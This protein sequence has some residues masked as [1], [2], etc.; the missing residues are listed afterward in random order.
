MA[1]IAYFIIDGLQKN[2]YYINNPIWVDITSLEGIEYVRLTMIYEGDAT[3]QKLY[4]NNSKTYFDIAPIV[5]GFMPAPKHPDTFVNNQDLGTNWLTLGITM[6]TI[7][8]SGTVIGVKSFFKTFVRGG[9]A[10]SQTN[11]F[12]NP[13]TVL[14]ESHLIPRWDAY[15]VV[16]YFINTYGFVSATNI[17]SAS[18]TDSRREIGCESVYVRFLNTKGGYSFWL[19][20]NWVMTEKTKGGKVVEARRGNYDTGVTEDSYSIAMNGRVGKEYYRTMEALAKSTE[21][22]VWGLN[23]LEFGDSAAEAVTTWARVHNPGNSVKLNKSKDVDNFSFNF[24][25]MFTNK[26]S[27]VW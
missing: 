21:V 25:A 11:L 19:F 14:K 18:E 9:K 13:N 3:Q 2:L 10:T 8:A 17:L 5:K 6:E 27:I 16:K 22:Y 24:E 23:E 4:V 1:A 12:T 26:P 7:S 15:P 20:E